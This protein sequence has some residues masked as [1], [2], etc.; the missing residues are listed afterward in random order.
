MSVKFDVKMT[1][2][3]M[4]D[5]MLYTSLTSMTGILGIVAGGLLLVVGIKQLLSGEIGTGMTYFM[6][7]AIF[8]VINPVN[9]KIRAG[10]QVKRT[11]MF[12]KPLTYE[13]DEKGVKVT[14]DDQSAENSWEDF[15]KVISTNKSIIMF[16]TKKRAIIFPK[17]YLGEQYADVVKVISTHMPA[18]KVNIRHVS[19][20]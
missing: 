6:F 11:P 15:Q 8:L 17:E 14:Q 13:L 20:S 10:E 9:M 16:V 18:K 3:A 19:A 7:A 4:Y 12:Q 2:E 5:F 1:K